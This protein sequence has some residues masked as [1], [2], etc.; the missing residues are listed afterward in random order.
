MSGMTTLTTMHRFIVLSPLGMLAI[1][2]LIAPRLQLYTDLVCK[3]LDGGHWDPKNGA[4]E[5]DT[6]S[7]GLPRTVPCAA[8]P[9]VQAKVAELLTGS[10][11]WLLTSSLSCVLRSP[12]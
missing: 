6:W 9:V 8:D 3:H 10:S 5:P 11:L 1:S 12:L 7:Q 2:A 4:T